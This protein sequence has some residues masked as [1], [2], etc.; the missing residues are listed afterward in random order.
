MATIMIS[1]VSQSSTQLHNRGASS[2]IAI[3]LTSSIT[4]SPNKD[5]ESPSDHGAGTLIQI[6]TVGKNNGATTGYSSHDQ[7]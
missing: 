7:L 5:H 2:N 4:A 6:A 3:A 1:Y